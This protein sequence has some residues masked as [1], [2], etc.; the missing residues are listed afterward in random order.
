MKK[1]TIFIN[2]ASYRDPELGLTVEDCYKKSKNP[3]NLFFSIVSDANDSE[4]PN[5]SFIPKNQIRYIKRDISKSSGVCSAR[6]LAMDG[7]LEFEHVLLI[8][9][10]SRFVQ[11]WDEE[12]LSMYKKSQ[13]FYGEKIIITS[14]PTGYGIDEYTK[15]YVFHNSGNLTSVKPMYDKN[16]KML[17]SQ[18][19]HDY[20][21]KNKDYGDEHFA[22]VGCSAFMSS[23]V[24]SLI[25]YDPNVY[26]FGEEPSMSLRAYT[27]GIK[28]IV[29]TKNYMYTKYK[30]LSDGVD[31]INNW[32]GRDIG[33]ES[34]NL[35]EKMS[36][37]RL[38]MVF[39]G[40]KDLGVFGIKSSDLWEEWQS[41]TGIDLMSLDFDR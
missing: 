28:S 6:S 31:A 19:N 33:H 8:D 12:I 4:H 11:F 16:I 17:V 5:L 26:F 21:Q 13:S 3:E 20:V 1:N 37:A 24:S 36:N 25:P 14:Y 34:R 23:Y 10:H 27:L 32:H 15:D 9:S 2:I 29:P 35:L 38:K 30:M 41:L 18:I 7:S 22:F 39:Q 40:D